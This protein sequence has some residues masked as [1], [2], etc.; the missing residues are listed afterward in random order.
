[1]TGDEALQHAVVDPDAPSDSLDRYY[2]LR[3]AF[4]DYVRYFE[5]WRSRSKGARKDLKCVLDVAYGEG[6]RE[7]I[8]FF[9]GA[10]ADGRLF[11]FV[12]GGYWRSMD[13]SDFSFIALPYVRRNVSVAVINYSLF[14]GITMPE[15][16]Q[17]V[18]NACAWVGA[19]S[20]RHGAPCQELHLGGW[21]A[22][23]HL[24]AMAASME[25]GSTTSS[26]IVEV[27]SVLAI[28]GVFDLR[29]LLRTSANADLKLDETTAMQNSPRFL[30]PRQSQRMA[31]LWGGNETD[32]FREQ[33]RALQNSWQHM[34]V[35]ICA[36]EVSGLHHYSVMNELAEEDSRVLQHSLDLLTRCG[37]RGPQ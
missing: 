7:R 6:E 33:S 21:S 13:K 17:Q 23:A 4:P 15:L 10:K 11:V 35:G 30:R 19:N 2:D 36:E 12:H 8:D 5:D 26:P 16:V 9:P 34:G 37:G 27:A 14:P 24:V 29:P 28:S 22:G 3:S 31:L 1:M 18:R 32:A 25:N 20:W